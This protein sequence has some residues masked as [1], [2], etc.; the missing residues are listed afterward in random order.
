LGSVRIRLDR[1]VL[2]RGGLKCSRHCRRSTFSSAES[3]ASFC[4]HGD[5]LP[6]PFFSRL[7]LIV[8]GCGHWSTRLDDTR[9]VNLL[10]LPR[11]SAQCCCRSK[12][13]GR[14]PLL[15]NV[16]GMAAAPPASDVGSFSPSLA[17]RGGS[18]CQVQNLAPSRKGFKIKVPSRNCSASRPIGE[19]RSEFADCSTSLLQRTL[20]VRSWLVE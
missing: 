8:E 16:I 17:K 20:L 4:D 15:P 6:R 19:I 12:S 3:I 18:L 10:V 14:A 11:V 9:S 13:A 1:S 5:T 2:L 7:K